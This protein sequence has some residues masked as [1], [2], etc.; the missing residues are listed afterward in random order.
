ML[1]RQVKFKSDIDHVFK[2][3]NHLYRCGIVLCNDCGQHQPVDNDYCFA[4]E[5]P[6]T[7]IIK[8]PKLKANAK[9]NTKVAQN[10]TADNNI[11]I[12][13]RIPLFSANRT[14]NT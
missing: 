13:N 8:K 10:T 3:P 14:P 11:G 1:I 2:T 4:C 5:L 6:L 7:Y 9:K 12:S